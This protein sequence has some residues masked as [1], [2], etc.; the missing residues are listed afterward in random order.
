M[1]TFFL[2]FGFL[3]WTGC[4]SA[5]ETPSGPAMPSGSGPTD[6]VSQPEKPEPLMRTS[7]QCC[8]DLKLEKAVRSYTLIGSNLANGTLSNPEYQGM[9]EA[10][11]SISKSPDDFAEPIAQL[12]SSDPSD[13]ARVR[14][15]YGDL[16][17]IVLTR[18]EAS[19]S[20]S[21][22]LDLA[23]GYSRA[24]D[25][26]WAQEGVEPKSPYG[27][28]I[29][30]YSWGRRGEVQAIDAQ[31]EEELGNNQLGATP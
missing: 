4:G 26:H 12:K 11:E 14:E 3:W 8:A 22:E 20:S 2:C 1:K 7:I 23:V 24:A 9:I 28:G 13:L 10:F 17:E 25:R 6:L 5:E 30:S 21:G 29:Q 18:I 27:D 31:R 15:I 19:S 16:S